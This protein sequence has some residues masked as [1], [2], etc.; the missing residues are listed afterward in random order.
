MQNV[1][2]LFDIPYYQR[3]A[4]NLEKALV[5]KYDGKW[6]ATSSQEYIDKANAISRA[7]LRL[8]V[9]KDDKIALITMTNRT[10]WNVMDIGILQV[11]A[12][13]VPIYPTVTA[14]DYQYILD[15]SQTSFC[16]VSCQA[17]F[18]KISS[19]RDQV[20][21]LKEVYSFDRIDGCKHWSEL[22]ELGADDSNQD[23]VESR[24]D[25]VAPD[26]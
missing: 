25:S 3:D 1:T 9:Q 18:D 13:N 7:L 17:V 15:H 5:T 4:F 14:E 10:E 26:D 19:I 16:F 21:S 2:R 22:L 20:P 12:Q 8:G 24:K 6:E 23:E 11:G